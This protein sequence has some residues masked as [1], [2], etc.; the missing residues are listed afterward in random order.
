MLGP[1]CDSSYKTTNNSI[2]MD[3]AGVCQNFAII[4]PKPGKERVENG[5]NGE[6]QQKAVVA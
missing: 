6:N 4:L 2:G 5:R 3:I 1:G